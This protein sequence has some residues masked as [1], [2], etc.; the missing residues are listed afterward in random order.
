[1]MQPPDLRRK[2][3]IIKEVVVVVA[4]LL[5]DGDLGHPFHH[6][7]PD[8]PWDNHAHRVTVVG[9]EPLSILLECDNDVHGRV[10]GLVNAKTC[11]IISVGQL[12]GALH[13]HEARP[14][15][16]VLDTGFQ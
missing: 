4:F 2:N 8:P 1:M 15:F 9:D 6:P 3:A 10:H 11:A 14:V 12:V 13:A 16:L 5:G 7:P